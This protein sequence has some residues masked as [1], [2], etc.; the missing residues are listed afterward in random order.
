MVAPLKA[1]FDC[2]IPIRRS[3][4]FNH[5][6]K[7]KSKVKTEPIVMVFTSQKHQEYILLCLGTLF[8]FNHNLIA[9]S[10]TP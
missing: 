10:D 3:I 5:K 6:T 9:L 1:R 7:N 8:S 4:L 2:V